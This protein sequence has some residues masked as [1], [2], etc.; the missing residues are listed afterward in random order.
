MG[1]TESDKERLDQILERANQRIEER[2]F[3]ADRD[4]DKIA[5]ILHR[6]ELAASEEHRLLV[7][8]KQDFAGPIRHQEKADRSET[9]T[10]FPQID[11]WRKSQD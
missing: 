10:E 4:E 11:R 6:A 7:E 5:E 3:P 8:S 1:L 9:L 2:E